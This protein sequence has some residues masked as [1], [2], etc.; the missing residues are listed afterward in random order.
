MSLDADNN[1]ELNVIIDTARNYFRNQWT[2]TNE[3]IG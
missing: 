3:V 2:I 1:A